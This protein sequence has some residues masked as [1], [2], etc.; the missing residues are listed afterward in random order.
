MN[1]MS[2]ALKSLIIMF[3]ISK[4]WKP[5]VQA[6]L[7]SSTYFGCFIGSLVTFKAINYSPRK[8]IMLLDIFLICGSLL[9]ISENIYVF[10]LGRL[11]AGIGCGMHSIMVPL[12]VKSFAPK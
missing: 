6:C 3:G 1:G 8:T 12:Y 5:F 10:L 2:D 4:D 7:S 9:E 11:I